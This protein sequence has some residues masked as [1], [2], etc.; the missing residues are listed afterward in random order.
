MSVPTLDLFAWWALCISFSSA[1]LVVI[2]IYLYSGNRTKRR[3]KDEKQAKEA[4]TARLIKNFT[5]VWVLLGLLVFYIFSI[6]L[7]LSQLG[8]GTLSE[9]VFAFGNIIVEILLVF[10]LLRNREKIPA[11]DRKKSDRT[12]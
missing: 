9:V 1:F 6:Q 5:F 4:N 3:D 2:S 8:A 7:A 12:Q 11:E 10:Y